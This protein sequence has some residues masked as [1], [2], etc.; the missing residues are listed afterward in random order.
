[1][2]SRYLFFTNECV[3][4][5]HLR[6]AL[7]LARA[8]T[9][10]DP[11]ASALIVTGAPVELAHPLPPRVDTVKLPLLARDASGVH[12][13][14]RLGLDPPA[15]RAMRSQLALVAAQSFAPHVAVVDKA[16]LGLG[17]ELAPAL[18]WLRRAG[19]T[20][21]LG[22]RDI[23]DEPRSV[24][25][26][27]DRPQ[28]RGALERLYDAVLVYGPEGA[29]LH[30]LACLD[31]EPDLPVHHVGWVASR[32]TAM[33]TGLPDEYVLVTAGGGADGA[34]MMGAF[35]DAVR[36]E[37]LPVAS[38]V[39][40]GPL[41]PEAAVRSLR[42]RAASLDVVVE[43]FM[44]SLDGAIAA[45]RGVVAMA[46][47][48]TVSELLRSGRPALLV[49]RTRPSR[50]QVLRAELLRA[51]GRA[52]VLYPHELDAQRMR[53]SLERLLAT[54]PHPEEDDHNGAR[55]ASEVLATIRR[56]G[57]ELAEAS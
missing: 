3:G 25:R 11:D 33:P 36:L 45:A 40:T 5:G 16:P 10:H 44:T 29:D 41:M 7:A 37:P 35:L 18:E 34:D 53:T 52:Q 8:V 15:V 31:W 56:A 54:A 42:A 19:T 14:G 39:V 43:T 30:A 23:E 13:A 17:G 2:S 38:L 21:A 12:R 28:V 47:Y 1:M 20:L 22:L 46:G 57:V 32:P 48:N 24:R 49:P 6:R 26:E 27:W 51:T 4:L 55:R 50:E 9:E